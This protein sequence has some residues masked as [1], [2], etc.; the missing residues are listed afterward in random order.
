MYIKPLGKRV[1]LKKVEVDN[2]TESGIILPDEAK[3][4]PVY[5]EI[6][7][8]GS[9]VENELIKAGAKVLYK[10]YSGTEVEVDDKEFIIID[11]EDLLG[12]LE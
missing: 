9:E 3:E 7:S 1:V 8:V 12:I 11:S 5:A 10:K 6:V 4:E 2:K